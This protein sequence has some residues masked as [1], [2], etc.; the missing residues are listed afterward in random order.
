MTDW[1]S[2]S[3]QSSY[4]KTA[5]TRPMMSDPQSYRKFAMSIEQEQWHHDDLVTTVYAVL[6]DNPDDPNYRLAQLIVDAV[7]DWCLDD[8]FSD[9]E[10][11]LRFHARSRRSVGVGESK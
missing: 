7:E 10:K 1:P 8:R 2:W 9:R 3:G 5:C 6:T 4:W 11:W